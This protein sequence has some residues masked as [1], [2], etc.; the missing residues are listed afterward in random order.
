[1]FEGQNFEQLVRDVRAIA[2]DMARLKDDVRRIGGGAAA[3]ASEQARNKFYEAKAKAQ[4]FGQEADRLAHENV[5]QAIA[6][7]AGVG[8]VVG[9]LIKHLK[10]RRDHE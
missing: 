10:Y 6:I 2:D 8:L 9:A 5:W 4:Q 7:A 3:E 1:M